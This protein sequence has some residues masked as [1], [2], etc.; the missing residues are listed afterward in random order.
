MRWGGTTAKCP[1]FDPSIIPSQP[2]R[3]DADGLGEAT[4]SGDLGLKTSALSRGEVVHAAVVT[5]VHVVMETVDP[6]T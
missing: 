2:A 4:V 6:I 5:V 3:H 1:I